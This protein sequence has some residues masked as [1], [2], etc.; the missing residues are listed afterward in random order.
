MGALFGG[1]LPHS[2]AYVAGGFTAV[3][4]SANLATFEAHL[5]AIIDFIDTRRDT[6]HEVPACVC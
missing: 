3:P 4:S 5:D 6:L 2:P 1:K